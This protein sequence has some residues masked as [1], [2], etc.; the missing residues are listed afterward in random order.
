MTKLTI[1]MATYDDFDGVYFSIQALRMY[2]PICETSDVEFIVIDN[3]PNGKHGEPNKKLMTWLRD[4]GKYIPYTARTTTAVRNEIFRN[5]SG[6]YTI[7]MDC[8]VMFMPGAIE[9]LLKYYDNNPDC[10]DIVQG[11]LMYDGLKGCLTHFK[12]IWG[13][14]MYGK[15]GTDKA[16]LDSG[17]AFDIPM[18]GLGVFSCE[19]KNWRG[20]NKL[21]KGFGGEEGYIHEKFRQMGGRS[22]CV[23]DFK[24]V[25]RFARP[26]GVKYPLKLEDR[27]WNYFIGWMELQGPESE[28]INK[29]E[30]VF[31]ACMPP[32]RVQR[33]RQEAR[34]ALKL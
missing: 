6:K 21:F 4:R 1:G 17:E 29:I 15:W 24:W 9:G 19:T 34:K 25:H 30:E 32:V 10:K 3:N 2:F 28:M 33:I 8:H 5:A 18:Q 12:P 14:M 20:F 16:G 13:K 7:S 23:P 31:S 11:P 26:E 22:I 27:V